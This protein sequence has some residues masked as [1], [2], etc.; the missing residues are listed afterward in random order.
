[1][2]LFDNEKGRYLCCLTEWLICPSLWLGRRKTINDEH[3]KAFKC[4]NEQNRKERILWG[5]TKWK[6]ETRNDGQNTN[7]SFHLEGN[8]GFLWTWFLLSQFCNTQRKVRIFYWWLE[9]SNSIAKSVNIKF[10]NMP[11][12]KRKCDSKNSEDFIR[13]CF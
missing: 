2:N 10:K 11:R 12:E 3:I 1:M 6:E 4:I 5:K 8:C 13:R 7:S 9:M